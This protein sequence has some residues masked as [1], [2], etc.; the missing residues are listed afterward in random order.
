LQTATLRFWASSLLLILLFSFLAKPVEK[1]LDLISLSQKPVTERIVEL[2][3]ILNQNSYSN[4]RNSIVLLLGKSYI[5]NKEF[6]KA[7][8]VLSDNTILDSD[9][10]E[11]AVYFLI[12]AKTELNKNFFPED[13]WKKLAFAEGEPS[14]RIE[15]LKN[16]ANNCLTTKNYEKAAAFLEQLPVEEK[17]SAEVIS[18][19]AICYT[20]IKRESEAFLNAKKLYIKYPLN[21]AGVDFFKKYPLL[22][23][24]MADLSDD[25]KKE[26]L[27]VLESVK[28]FFSFEKELKEAQSFLTDDE[29]TFFNAALLSFK[30]NKFEAIT[31]Y[32]SIS[33][34]SPL[35]KISLL[36]AAQNISSIS[37]KT[38][39]LE[40]KAVF[41]PECSEKEKILSIIFNLYKKMEFN[42]DAQRVAKELLKFANAD[43]SEFLFKKAFENYLNGNRKECAEIL[44]EI[45]ATLPKD[46]DYHQAALFSLIKMDKLGKEEKESAKRELLNSSKYGYY[47]YKLR[48]GA[49][50][51]IEAETQFLPPFIPNPVPKSRV[52][53]SN[54]LIESGLTEE[55]VAELEA[56]LSKEEKPEYLWLMALTASKGMMYPKSV[57]AVRKLYPYAYSE[58]GDKIPQQAWEMLYPVPYYEYFEKVSKENKMP[59]T[60]LLSIAR[61]ESLFDRKAVSKA[62]A[63]GMIQLI[64]STAVIAAKKAGLPFSSKEQLFDVEYNLKIG[65]TYFLSVYEN[66]DKNLVSALGGYNAGPGNMKN[67][68][69]RRNNPA[70][71]ELFVESIPFKETR[72]YIK[73]ILNNIY[74]YERIYP[75]LKNKGGNF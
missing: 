28:G 64:P 7:E 26:R 58:E 32:L 36:R 10:G 27:F 25:E 43:A 5:E 17:E 21:K 56:V 47:G 42:D 2:E 35:Y 40:K 16:L 59:I 54:L 72:G 18:N 6:E 60:L 52:Y 46:N 65:S 71:E 50:P 29:K 63:M 48:K 44:K 53:K 37:S 14:F 9:L 24:K 70:D 20:E 11:Y 34:N 67:W 23:G 1:E 22:L 68:R 3:D 33:Q 75:E 66:F 31:K 19:L 49:L 73:R 69:N 4:Q 74:E 15:A 41:M 8:K 51:K 57:R 45:A 38:I 61:Q 30:G 39:E 62:N 12:S 13:L 55:A